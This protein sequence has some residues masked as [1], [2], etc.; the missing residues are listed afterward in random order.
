MGPT[1]QHMWDQEKFHKQEMERLIRKHRVRPTVMTPF[2]NVAGFALG[3]GTALLGEKAAMACTVAVESVIVEHYNSQLRQLMDSKNPDK[4]ILD[5]ITK[6]RDEELEHHDKGL[7]H[8]AEQA[9]FYDALTNVIKMGCKVAI[10]IS[11]KI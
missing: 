11:E 3:A 10:K 2:W 6:F 7:D 1:I 8:G 9:P 4:E 5:L